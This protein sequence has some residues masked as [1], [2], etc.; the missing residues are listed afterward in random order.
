[1]SNTYRDESLGGF[2]AY[3]EEVVGDKDG[4][5]EGARHYGSRRFLQYGDCL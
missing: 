1:M 5:G 3:S 2:T 4:L